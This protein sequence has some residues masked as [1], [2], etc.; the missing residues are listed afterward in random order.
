MMGDLAGLMSGI[1]ALQEPEQWT[2]LDKCQTLAAMIV[3]NRPKVVV[4]VGVWEGSS[5][6]PQLLALKHVGGGIGIAIDSWSAIA[7]IE[8]QVDPANVNWWGKQSIH[9]H[10][11]QKFCGLLAKHGLV[12]ICRVVRSRS[13]AVDVKSVVDSYGPID[14]L[15]V[16][17]NHGDAAIG[18]VERFAPHIPVGGLLILDDCDWTGG[19]VKRAHDLAIKMGFSHRYVLGTGEV[20]QRVR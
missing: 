9:D 8:G 17:G 7:S 11:Y 4:E 3:A 2:K 1:A 20:L 5:F 18:D 19:S 14:M 12:D 6:L 15:H 16:D 13:D 10:A